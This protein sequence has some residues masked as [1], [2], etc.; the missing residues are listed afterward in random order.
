MKSR[1]VLLAPLIL[2]L[3]SCSTT[4]HTTTTQQPPPPTNIPIKVTAVELTRLYEQNVVAADYTYTQKLVTVSG[5]V[6]A[7][8]RFEDSIH[9]HLAA[10]LQPYTREYVTCVFSNDHFRGVL[11]LRKG[12]SSTITGTCQG[13][14]WE[15]IVLTECYTPE[16]FAPSRQD[17]LPALRLSPSRNSVLAPAPVGAT[18]RCRDGTYSY[19][20]SRRGTCSWHGGVAAWLR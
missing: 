9:V 15:T 3:A 16:S 10:A 6:V 14:L 2:F 12:E 17:N 4:P 19:S 11:N 18:A 7:I 1:R 13:R 8:E 5:K 20:Q